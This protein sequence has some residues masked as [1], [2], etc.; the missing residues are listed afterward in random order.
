MEIPLELTCRNVEK[1]EALET[2]VRKKVAGLEQV[3]SYLSSCRIAVEKAQ[4]EHAG[5]PYRIRIDMT[6][7]PGHELAVTRNPGE[8]DSSELPQII[9]KAFEAAKRQLKKL[10]A[11]QRGHVK[12]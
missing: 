6:V 3:C 2:L 9:R 5:N 1:T 4:H 8:G 12:T 10:V 7:P 11:R